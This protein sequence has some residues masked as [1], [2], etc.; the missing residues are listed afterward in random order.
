MLVGKAINVRL[1]DESEAALILV[2]SADGVSSS[3]AVRTALLEARDRRLGD[4]AIRDAARRTWADP[5]Y[6]REVADWL[7]FRGDPFEG[8]PE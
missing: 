1:D 5:S 8:L 7:D 3:E 6:R 2:R 4:E